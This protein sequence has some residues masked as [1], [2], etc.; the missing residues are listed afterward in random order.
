MTATNITIPNL[1]KQKLSDK[2]PSDK[3]PVTI[4]CI[5]VGSDKTPV[6]VMALKGTT[7]FLFSDLKAIKDCDTKNMRFIKD[8][9]VKDK[10]VI[11]VKPSTHEIE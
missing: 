2:E 10:R 3:T 5:M 8:R 11:I 4:S 1:K 6:R 9:V 7:Y